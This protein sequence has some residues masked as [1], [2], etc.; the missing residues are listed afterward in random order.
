MAS[1]QIWFRSST[2][3]IPCHGFASGVRLYHQLARWQTLDNAHE[4]WY[5]VKPIR[6]GSRASS[7]PW[8]VIGSGDAIEG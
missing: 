2:S 3:R 8:D 5:P 7:Q 1:R 4:L 6:P